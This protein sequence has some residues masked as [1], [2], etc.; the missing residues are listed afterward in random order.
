[1]TPR[2]TPRKLPPTPT[3]TATGLLPEELPTDPDPA[4]V[5]NAWNWLS[6]AVRAG[7]G[8]GQD[9]LGEGQLMF[10]GEL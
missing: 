7:T 2:M 6:G 9:H 4:T 1:M 10:D 8:D 5:I 3:E